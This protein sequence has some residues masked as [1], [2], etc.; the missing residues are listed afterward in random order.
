VLIT[1]ISVNALHDLLNDALSSWECIA[2]NSKMFSAYSV[3]KD[4]K[5]CGSGVVL[6][7]CRGLL[8]EGPGKSTI[9][10]TIVCIT[11]YSAGTWAQFYRS[12][13]GLQLLFIFVDPFVV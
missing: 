2:S 11:A 7:C 5:I 10:I 4:V 8:P 13:A 12:R 9:N 3:V 1:D 6:R